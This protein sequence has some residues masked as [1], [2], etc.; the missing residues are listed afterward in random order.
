MRR[1]RL[2]TWWIKLSTSERQ[3]AYSVRV[4]RGQEQGACA[5]IAFGRQDDVLEAELR[6][7]AFEIVCLDL[8]RAVTS[9][10]DAQYAPARSKTRRESVNEL[11]AALRIGNV[12]ERTVEAG[13][14]TDLDCDSRKLDRAFEAD[15]AEPLDGLRLWAGQRSL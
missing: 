11:R 12:N 3:C 7:D 2:T 9:R 14:L 1:E 13:P 4:P 5:A 8:V 15:A 6:H 10:G